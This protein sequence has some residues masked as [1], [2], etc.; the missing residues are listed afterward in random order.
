ML[1]FNRPK[2]IKPSILTIHNQSQSIEANRSSINAITRQLLGSQSQV[3][4]SHDESVPAEAATNATGNTALIS[5]R[6]SEQEPQ[7]CSLGRERGLCGSLKE[8]QE[9]TSKIWNIVITLLIIAGI[10]L[11]ILTTVVIVV[12]FFSDLSTHL[13]GY[14]AD[15]TLKVVG[16]IVEGCLYYYFQLKTNYFKE[17][18][19]K[20]FG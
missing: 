11:I 9:S 1:F 8:N 17:N 14:K 10:G 2:G 13:F 3:A 16:C 12:P 18:G 6:D 20:N 5:Q 4:D 7:E 19:T 15:T